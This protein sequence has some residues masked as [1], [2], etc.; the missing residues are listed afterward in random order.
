VERRFRAL[1]TLLAM[2]RPTSAAVPY[3]EYAAPLEVM[4]EKGDIPTL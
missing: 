2:D 1:Q 3:E 4:M